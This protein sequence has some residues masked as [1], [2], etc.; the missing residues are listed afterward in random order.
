MSPF[1]DSM[2]AKLIVHADTREAA[3]AKLNDALERAVVIGPKT[4]IAFLSALLTSPEVRAGGYDT[5]FIDAHLTALG[6]APH[7]PDRRATL[8]AAESLWKRAGERPP[9]QGPVDPWS[10]A[11]SFELTGLRRVPI[12]SRASRAK[13]SGLLR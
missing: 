8:A 6:A 11:D 1:Y 10:V 13:S 7:E 12:R 9:M 4:N 3:L 5:G 2:I